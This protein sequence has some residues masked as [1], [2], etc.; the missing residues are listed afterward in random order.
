MSKLS[1]DPQD[2]NFEVRIGSSIEAD[3]N[4]RGRVSANLSDAGWE[5][6]LQNRNRL[7]VEMQFVSTVSDLINLN[8][9]M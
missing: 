3:S 1:A 4:L 8:L 2:G 6:G 9:S 7:V 5:P